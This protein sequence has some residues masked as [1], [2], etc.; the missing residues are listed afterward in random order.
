LSA[1]QRAARICRVGLVE[2]FDSKAHRGIWL[3]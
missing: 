2:G 3:C 1:Q